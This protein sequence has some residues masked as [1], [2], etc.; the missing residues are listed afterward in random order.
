MPSFPRT[1]EPRFARTPLA[2]IAR[3]IDQNWIPAFAGTTFSILETTPAHQYSRRSGLISCRIVVAISS[4]DFV[5]DDSQRIPSRRIIA[6]AS[7]TS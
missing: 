1:W 4:M 3:L 7:F 6:S 5:V 2:R